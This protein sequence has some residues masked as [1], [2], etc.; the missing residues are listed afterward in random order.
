MI[1]LRNGSY[2]ADGFTYTFSRASNP[3]SIRLEFVGAEAHEFANRIPAQPTW[4][5]NAAELRAYAGRWLSDELAVSWRTEQRGDTLVLLRP[6]AP[7]VTMEPLDRDQFRA[8]VRN[9]A[10]FATWVGITYVRDA[11]GRLDGFTASSVPAAF[12]VA[13]GLRFERIP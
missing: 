1:R 6:G 13:L 3:S 11:T 4:R 9:G 10:G 5:P 2:V 8:S 7:D 12:E